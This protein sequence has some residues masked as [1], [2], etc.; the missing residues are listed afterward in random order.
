MLEI[1]PSSRI[2]TSIS[3]SPFWHHSGCWRDWGYQ[4]LSRLLPQLTRRS[5]PQT[6]CSRR[7]LPTGGKWRRLVPC[8]RLICGTISEG[9]NQSFR[10]HWKLA[11]NLLI[12]YGAPL[13]YRHGR[14]A[15]AS[16][17]SSC[18]GLAVIVHRRRNHYPS[19][20]SALRLGERDSA[21]S[22]HRFLLRGMNPP[23]SLFTVV[24]PP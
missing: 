5:L 1:L 21:H 24:D 11:L 22:S 23:T 9:L 7:A 15:V 2:I 3:P 8:S 6:P 17:E 16:L 12:V 4:H 13:P 20:L 10:R 14:R 18:T 19:A